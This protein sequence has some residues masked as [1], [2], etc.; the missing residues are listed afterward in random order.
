MRSEAAEQRWNDVH[1]SHYMSIHIIIFH[2]RTSVACSR[3]N[4]GRVSIGNV[5]KNTLVSIDESVT[6]NWRI[7]FS[8]HLSHH[9]TYA[10]FY[11]QKTAVVD[12]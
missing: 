4:E 1:D 5:P 8:R 9:P 12:K 7:E 3:V 6:D 10:V 11:H 2:V